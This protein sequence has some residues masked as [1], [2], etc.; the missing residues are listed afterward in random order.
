MSTDTD[1]K[2]QQAFERLMRAHPEIT[3]GAISVSNICV[4]AGVS[5]ASYYRSP[6]AATIKQLLDA[7]QTQ[8]PEIEDL[9][10]HVKELKKT[11]RDLRH[12]HAAQIRE[13]RDTIKTYANQIQAL[14]LRASQL[15]DDN[16]RLQ[17]SLDSAASN[18]TPLNNG[19]R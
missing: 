3:N 12:E 8:C 5:R 7:P 15:R 9:R 16:H 13:N 6:R 19:H 10:Q 4:E 14:A 1:T 18:I 11:E 2:I 17:A